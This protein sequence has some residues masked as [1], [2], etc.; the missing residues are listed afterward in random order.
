MW[1]ICHIFN[2]LYILLDKYKKHMTKRQIITCEQKIKQ[3]NI[4]TNS[5]IAFSLHI[6]NSCCI[7]IKMNNNLNKLLDYIEIHSHRK[8]NFRLFISLLID[9]SKSKNLK[10]DFDELIFRGKFIFNAT[11]ILNQRTLDP[12]H[13][14]NLIKEFEFSLENFISQL[15]N[16]SEHLDPT[17]KTEFQ[18]LFIEN[19]KL[20]DLFLLIEDLKDIKNYEIDNRVEVV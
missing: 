8:F 18:N 15:R 9:T 19:D 1:Q 12:E 20:D 6:F 17:Y 7:F 13:Y 5:H 4:M 3:K 14:N 10:K 2:G 11:R 16:M